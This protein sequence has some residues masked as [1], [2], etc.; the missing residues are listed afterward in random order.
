M[1]LAVTL[2]VPSS[3]TGCE[4]E[5]CRSPA[6]GSSP[7]RSSAWAWKPGPRAFLMGILGMPVKA[8]VPKA[9]PAIEMPTVWRLIQYWQETCSVNSRYTS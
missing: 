9:P 6:N 2:G 7:A 1:A 4:P 8:G 3:S 5:K